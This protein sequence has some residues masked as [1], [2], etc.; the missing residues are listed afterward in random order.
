MCTS[1][2]NTG[3]DETD[4]RVQVN[5]S[6]TLQQTGLGHND[7]ALF[8]IKKQTYHTVRSKAA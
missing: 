5:R 4:R 7:R 6:E 1:T 3:E 8:D 2:R